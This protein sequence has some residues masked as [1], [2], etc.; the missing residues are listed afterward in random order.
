VLLLLA[1]CAPR[2]GAGLVPELT[3]PAARGSLAPNW[4]LVAGQPALTW[5]EPAGAPGAPGPPWRLR[6]ARLG[7]GT[8]PVT[9]AEGG[10]YFANWADFPSVVEAAD[11]ALYA[12]WLEKVGTGTYAYGIQMA[13]SSDSGATWKRLGLLHQDGTETEHGFVTLLPEASGVRAV[14]LDGRETA[15]G[16]AMTLRTALVDE[17]VRTETEERLDERICDC[18][19]TA[20]V[21]TPDGPL[22]A[23]RD[24]GPTEIRDIS[25]LR[26]SSAGWSAPAALHEDGWE[27]AGCPVNGPALAT[28]GDTV[29]AAWFTAQGEHP[30]VLAAVSADRGAS[31]GPPIEIDTTAP[32]GRV[33]LATGPDGAA[34]LSW[35]GADG[36]TGVLRI[37]KLDV[38]G[39]LGPV[40]EVARTATT[41]GSGVPR[42]LIHGEKVHLAWVHPGDK[43][44]GEPSRIVVKPLILLM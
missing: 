19:S 13:R 11:G 38:Q 34:V 16:G 44:Q 4:A 8:P 41:R 40:R 37:V 15:T 6:F 28:D 39:R 7:T 21:S 14:W 9:I 32:L 18:C 22:V 3:S 29:W 33:G 26:H 12:H 27:I 5:W 43:E 10:E 30:R 2:P 31:F 1:S 20:A 36:D 35:L 17:H 42:L 25:L 24:R 23:Y